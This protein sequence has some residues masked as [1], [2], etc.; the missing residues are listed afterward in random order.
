L[1]FGVLVFVEGGKLESPEKNPRRKARA[2]NKLN[3]QMAP[4]QNP[5]RATLVEDKRSHNYTI[6]APHIDLLKTIY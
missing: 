2:N 1:E 6:P 4:G 3:P 5:T